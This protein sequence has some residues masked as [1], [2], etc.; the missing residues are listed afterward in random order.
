LFLRPP[1]ILLRVRCLARPVKEQFSATRRTR[2]HVYA[3]AYGIKL[4]LMN[5]ATVGRRG[6][7]LMQTNGFWSPAAGGAPAGS[8]ATGAADRPARP[9]PARR[10]CSDRR[11][12]TMSLHHFPGKTMCRNIRTL[13][14]FAPPATDDEV[15]AAALQFVRKLSGYNAPSKANEAAFQRAVEQV[16]AV[17]RELI[18]SLVTTA[19]PRDRQI[20]AQRAKVRN[21]TRF[22]RHKP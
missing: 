9:W 5:G 18:D 12:G 15:G 17:A 10:F 4:F 1:Q 22:A 7:N 11:P 2:E 13:F 14:N 19:A 6:Y 20:E 16:A 21:A 3:I 8:R